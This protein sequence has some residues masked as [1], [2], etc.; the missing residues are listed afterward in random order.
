MPSFTT[1]H[2]PP[3]IRRGGA[4]KSNLSELTRTGNTLGPRLPAQG[5]YNPLDHTSLI[6]QWR[7]VKN[8]ALKPHIRLRAQLHLQTDCPSGLQR[9]A[10]A[11]LEVAAHG[12][13]TVVREEFEDFDTD[14][15]GAVASRSDWEEQFRDPLREEG[16]EE[17]AVI[18][19]EKLVPKNV[20]KTPW[21][22]KAS[23]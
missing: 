22:Q 13:A 17:C 15:G 2:T 21:C 20:S 10:N 23:G 19:Y 6:L 7:P 1:K 9:I 14:V 5:K 18:D 12:S 8:K 4:N 16:D 3:Y 11:R